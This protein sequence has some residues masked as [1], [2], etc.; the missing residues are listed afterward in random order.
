MHDAVAVQ[1]IPLSRLAPWLALVPLFL[2]VLYL[3]GLDQGVISQAGSYLHELMHDGR[4]LLA[5]PC[6]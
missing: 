5:L 4:H 6:H 2:M 3:M 1:P